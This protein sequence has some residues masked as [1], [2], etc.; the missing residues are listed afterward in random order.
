MI[1]I[2]LLKKTQINLIYVKIVNKYSIID[3]NIKKYI[4]IMDFL[5]KNNNN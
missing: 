2:I 4:K 5:K 3:K 1:N